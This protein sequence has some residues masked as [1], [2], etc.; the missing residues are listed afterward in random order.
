MPTRFGMCYPQAIEHITKIVQVRAHG[1][2]KILAQDDEDVKN[3]NMRLPD[4]CFR[5][6][7][8][9]PTRRCKVSSDHRGCCFRIPLQEKVWPEQAQFLSVERL[10]AASQRIVNAPP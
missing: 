8:Q 5:S 2:F 4:G 3:Q 10:N 9:R 6:H 1:S 7:Q